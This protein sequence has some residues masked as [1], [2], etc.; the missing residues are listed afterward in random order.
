MSSDTGRGEI[1]GRS[2]TAVYCID[3]GR[4]VP[5]VTAAEYSQPPVGFTNR[6]PGETGT[7]GVWGTTRDR[8][9]A[10]GAA[11]LPPLL[12][13]GGGDGVRGIHRLPSLS[14]ELR[15]GFADGSLMS[16]EDRER[17]DNARDCLLYDVTLLVEYRSGEVS[18]ETVV[19][20]ALSP[21]ELRERRD[22]PRSWS[23][24]S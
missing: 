9:R 2:E 24:T 1:M 7:G 5:G 23:S 3:A 15:P 20:R 4:S 16:T 13:V 6:S 8:V 17:V 21:P 18:G 10:A 22:G 14:V 19:I 11:R 12:L